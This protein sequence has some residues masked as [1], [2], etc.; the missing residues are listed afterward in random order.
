MDY[1][2]VDILPTTSHADL[3]KKASIFM[4]ALKDAKA[5]LYAGTILKSDLSLSWSGVPE[6]ASSGQARPRTTPTPVSGSLISSSRLQAR[7][8]CASLSL[9]DDVN[10]C[11][12]PSLPRLEEAGKKLCSVFP[13]SVRKWQRDVD[14]RVSLVDIDGLVL[15]PGEVMILASGFFFRS[16][17]ELLPA[18]SGMDGYHVHRILAD[19]RYASAASLFEVPAYRCLGVTP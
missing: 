17:D 19:Y 13:G 5:E 2:D 3:A 7:T 15:P 1:A 14:R 16:H 8:A 10:R 6:F 18:T 12:Q 11:K 9:H 4:D